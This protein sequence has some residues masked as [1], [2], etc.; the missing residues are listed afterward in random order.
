[1][2]IY[3]CFIADGSS[4]SC[5]PHAPPAE[6]SQALTRSATTSSPTATTGSSEG[7]HLSIDDRMALAKENRAKEEQ[8]SE[9]AAALS[10]RARMSES[11]KCKS[12]SLLHYKPSTAG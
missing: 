6:I 11:G 4:Q 5:I 3:C 10:R 7:R 9:L 12:I 1:M 8:E 2:H